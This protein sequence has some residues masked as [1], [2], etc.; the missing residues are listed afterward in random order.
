MKTL[1][2]PNYDNLREDVGLSGVT[3]DPADRGKFR[4]PSLREVAL[5]APYMHNGVLAT[6]QDVIEFYDRGGGP[7]PNRS[8]LLKPLGLTAS[9]KQAL[10]EFLRALTG[11][12]V[13]VEPPALPEYKLRTLGKN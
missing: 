7:H 5:T 3:K 6:L 1:G 12:T 9:D 8:P 4:T 11:E 10:G 13:V 2:A